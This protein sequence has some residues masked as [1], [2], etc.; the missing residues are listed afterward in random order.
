MT[1]GRTTNVKQCVE[2]INRRESIVEN[3]DVKEYEGGRTK[4]QG[5][6]Y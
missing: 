3:G 4:E 6:E 5:I 1:S 2:E